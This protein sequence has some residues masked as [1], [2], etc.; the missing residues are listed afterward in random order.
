MADNPYFEKLLAEMSALHAKKNHD[1]ASDADPFSNFRFA[2]QQ[3]GVDPH[4]VLEVLIGVKTARLRELTGS[5]KVPNNESERDTRLDRAMY[6]AI[7][8]AL[9]DQERE[10]ARLAALPAEVPQRSDEVVGDA[11]FWRNLERT[12]GAKA[13]EEEWLPQH[14]VPL[15]PHQVKGQGWGGGKPA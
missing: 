2:A 8:V 12:T 1:Y 11:D 4:T 7:D 3:A 6:A 10:Q 5:G 9:Y 14:R 13:P 15:N